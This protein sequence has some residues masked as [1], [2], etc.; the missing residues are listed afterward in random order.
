MSAITFSAFVGNIL[1]IFKPVTLLLMSIATA[2]FIY[3]VVGVIAN[4]G[5][6][7]KLKEGKERM[8]WGII[9]LFVMVAMWGLAIVVSSSF[10]LGDTNIPNTD[11]A[12]WK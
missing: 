3:G 12:N 5:D 11:Y 9:A 2:Y 7:A 8:I 6:E 4:S 10:G 1:A